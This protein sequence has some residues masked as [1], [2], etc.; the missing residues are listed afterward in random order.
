MSPPARDH[1]LRRQ[2]ATQDHPVDVDVQ[3]SA[4]YRVWFVD[5]P[6]HGHDA[7]VVDQHVDRAELALDGVEESRKRIRVGDIEF[8]VHVEVEIGTRLFRHRLIDVADSDLGSQ[9]VQRGRCGQ[10]DPPGAAGDGDYFVLDLVPD[11]DADGCP[12]WHCRPFARRALAAVQCGRARVVTV[13]ANA[14][15]TATVCTCPN[16]CSMPCVCSTCPTAVLLEAPI[17]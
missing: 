11:L 7:G 12:A 2:L 17:W 1:P 13:A 10:S 6:P 9:V 3:D 5:N 8:A 14:D 4:G 15:E 16:D